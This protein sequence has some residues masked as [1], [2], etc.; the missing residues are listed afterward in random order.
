[1][2]RPLFTLATAMLLAGCAA[3]KVENPVT[4]ERQFVAG[5]TAKDEIALGLKAAPDV[6]KQHGG[7]D[8][9]NR[10]ERIQEEIRTRFPQG[11]P[12]GLV[13]GAPLGPR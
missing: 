6:A 11:V 5:I 9:G 7:E 10:E 13:L 12:K 1:M 4:V 3:M 2:L 8:P